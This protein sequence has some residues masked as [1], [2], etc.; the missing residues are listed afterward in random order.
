MAT[1]TAN[2]NGLNLVYEHEGSGPPI[3]F[4]HT[5]TGS[6]SQF[7]TLIPFLTDDY[8]CIAVELRGHGRS[9]R[10]PEGR[11]ITKHMVAEATAFIEQ[12]AGTISCI[13]VFLGAL[14]G[15]SSASYKKE[16]DLGEAA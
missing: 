16:K 8:T 12:V 5:F 4:L 7:E 10:S 15:I 9:D 14:L 11:Y 2:V 3:V 6:A 1:R 13:T